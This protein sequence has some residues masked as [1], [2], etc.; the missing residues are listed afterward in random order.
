MAAKNEEFIDSLRSQD[1]D[2]AIISSLERSNTA[3]MEI[4]EK[5]RRLLQDQILENCGEAS[6]VRGGNVE[7]SKM[8]WLKR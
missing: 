6:S 7:F 3:A 5:L 1:D 8:A 2:E 4:L